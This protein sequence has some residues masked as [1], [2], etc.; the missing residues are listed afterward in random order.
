[1]RIGIVAPDLRDIGG[2]REKALFVARTLRDQLGASV[3]L[4][5]LATSRV[6]NA[7][8]LLRRARTWGGLR[9]CRYTA[10]EFQV[11]HVGAVGAEIELARYGTR[12][13]ILNLTQ[14][15]DALHVVCGTP[16]LANAVR[17]FDGPVI[18]H[19]ASFVRHER[20]SGGSGRRTALDG[21]RQLMTAAVTVQERLA[22]RRADAIVAVN[23]LRMLEARAAARADTPVEVVHTGVDTDWFSPRS[24]RA[25]GYVLWVG[26]AGDP[27]KNVPLLLRA[28]A[29]ARGRRPTLP[30]LVLAGPSAPPPETRQSIAALGLTGTVQWR[31]PLDRHGLAELYRGASMFVL[32]SDEEGQSIAAVEAM[33]SGLPVVATS[34]VGPAEIITDGVEGVFAPVG[35]ADDLAAAIV[36]LDADPALRRRMAQDARRRAV[37]EFSLVCTGARLCN[38]YRAH[39][40]VGGADASRR[41]SSSS[42]ESEQRPW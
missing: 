13:A 24:Y 15:C 29:A 26:R 25:D 11:D 17:R 31:G 27:R 16:A 38:V 39:G 7:S 5:S 6:D 41:Q 8:I 21:W 20:R 1:M 37:R 22:L 42:P 33:A 10:D 19:F 32:S 28:Y 34:C 3:R 2:V 40:I 4:L 35:A 9:E 36:R 14:G 23:R 12:R 30:R 18:V